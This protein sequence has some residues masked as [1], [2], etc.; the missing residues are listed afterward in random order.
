ME[1]AE[2]FCTES[3]VQSIHDCVVTLSREILKRRY[4]I[5]ESLSLKHGMEEQRSGRIRAAAFVYEQLLQSNP[6]DSDAW[7][8]LGLVH[9]LYDMTDKDRALNAVRNFVDRAI[10]IRPEFNHY[11][12]N[13]VRILRSHRELYAEAC[14]YLRQSLERLSQDE[15]K[16]RA[17]YLS[18]LLFLLNEQGLYEN[19]VS[20]FNRW[21]RLPRNVK[22]PPSSNEALEFARQTIRTLGRALA[23]ALHDGKSLEEI[24]DTTYSLGRTAT[25][26]SHEAEVWNQVGL[27]LTY[28]R[29]FKDSIAFYSALTRVQPLVSRNWFNLGVACSALG[30]FDLSGLSQGTGVLLKHEQDYRQ[31]SVS[32]RTKQF[33]PRPSDHLV[34]AIYCDEYGNSWWGNWGPSS[35]GAGIGG[36]E[37]AVIYMSKELARI[38]DR[39]VWVE[40]YAKPPAHEIGVSDGVAWYPFEWYVMMMMLFFLLKTCNLRPPQQKLQVLHE[41]KRRTRCVRVMEIRNLNSIR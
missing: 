35:T 14:N 19:V 16:K 4:D 18:Q 25:L 1:R 9:H 5:Q 29:Q 21:N 34:I 24:E 23:E 20:S 10:S 32:D 7:H 22:P 33:V 3:N 13:A 31:S 12:E 17:D 39:K 38:H 8:L 30:E 15:S 41:N 2:I 27:A 28:N 37:E 40:V 6:K 11:R 26:S 36:S